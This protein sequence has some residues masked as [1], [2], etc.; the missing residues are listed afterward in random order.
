MFAARASLLVCIFVKSAAT[1]FSNYIHIHIQYSY[2]RVLEPTQVLPSIFADYV[3]VL[4][5]WTRF[6][7][8]T[9]FMHVISLTTPTYLW[10][11]MF[12]ARQTSLRCT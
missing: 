7:S 11:V 4:N 3:R 5:Y 2:V 6:C 12:K 1:E 8:G 9:S 10:F